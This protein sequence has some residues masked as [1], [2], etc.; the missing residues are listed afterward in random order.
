M[1][2][3]QVRELIAVVALSRV[4][5]T[6]QALNY[7]CEETCA[8]GVSDVLKEV[9]NDNNLEGLCTSYSCNTLYADMTDSEYWFEPA[10]WMDRGDILFFDWD[11]IAEEKPLDHVA[12]VINVHGDT[13]DYVNINGSDHNTWT[14]QSISKHNVSIAYWVR[15]INPTPTTQPVTPDQLNTKDDIKQVI[16]KLQ[17]LRDDITAKIDMYIR[18]LKNIK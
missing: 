12:I 3:E 14:I 9:F 18:S 17:V 6:R 15:Y 5:C 11:R 8:E 2:N 4:G 13:I 7:R 10:G 16:E 1:K